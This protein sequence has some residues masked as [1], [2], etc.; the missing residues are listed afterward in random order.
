MRYVICYDISSSRRRRRV[1]DCLDGYG[2]RIQESVFEAILDTRLFD[3]CISEIAGLIDPVE[4]SVAAYALCGTCDATRVYLGLAEQ[5]DIG[6]ES[7][8]IV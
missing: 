4:D 1:A 3:R 5:S 8:F 6:G 7:V 2:D